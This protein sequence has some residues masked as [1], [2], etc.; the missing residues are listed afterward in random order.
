MDTREVFE[1]K[2]FKKII[3]LEAESAVMHS[4]QKVNFYIEDDLLEESAFYLAGDDIFELVAVIS[5]SSDMRT[6]YHK[7]ILKTYYQYKNQMF[8]ITMMRLGEDISAIIKKGK[9]D[10]F[11][12][13]D[14]LI[15]EVK[16][17]NRY[18]SVKKGKLR[19]WIVLGMDEKDNISF[20]RHEYDTGYIECT[21]SLS[22]LIEK[23]KKGDM[24]S[25][26]AD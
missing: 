1:Q 13:T 3:E 26:S 4:N 11:P 23:L 17:G 10:L 2:I 16:V 14:I 15:P 21:L 19:T 18:Q 8:T 6:F 12:E 5:S 22:S 20:Y 24:Y 7:K 9:Y 25:V